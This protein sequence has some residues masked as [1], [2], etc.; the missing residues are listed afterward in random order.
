MR[1]M[2][3]LERFDA[4]L[5]REE[6]DRLCVMAFSTSL[7]IAK[8]SGLQVED[9]RWDPKLATVAGHAWMKYGADDFYYN[10]EL[11]APTK[12][13][14][15]ELRER[16]NH[17][18]SPKGFFFETPE[19]IESKEFPFDPT[20]PKK[21]PW[22]N[23][24]L[25]DKVSLAR[26]NWGDE[27]I[28]QP[29]FWGIITQAGLLRGVEA[30]MID[31]MLE[32]DLVHKLVNKTEDLIQGIQQ[33]LC[34]AGSH[35]I[36]NADPTGSE[37]LMDVDTYRKYLSDSNKRI[38]ADVKEN[39]DVKYVLHICG[40][41]AKTCQVAPEIGADIYSFDYQVPC[42]HYKKA[43]GDRCVI[44]GNIPTNTVT[45]IK[46]VQEVISAAR[47]CIEQGAEGGGYILGGACDVP[48]ESPFENVRSIVEAAE[49]YSDFDDWK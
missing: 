43:I 46:N 8:Y 21:T 14:G 13:C 22:M 37:D 31:M 38:V 5:A 23:K 35:S 15:V 48:I 18:C 41:T 24:G 19:D 28:I 44:L 33:R 17:H 3:R 11:M 30:L 2:T 12:D 9:I 36:M 1:R 49:N 32:E 40:D 47:S 16:Q 39:Y 10:S 7:M 42:A 34:E 26:E 4:T 27:F 6:L 25:F 45:M 29:G 20:D